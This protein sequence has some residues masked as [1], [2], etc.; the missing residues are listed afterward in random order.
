[1]FPDHV[2]EG[3]ILSNVMTAFDS[4]IPGFS[5][6]AMNLYVDEVIE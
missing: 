5:V 4:A 3:E 6:L 1:M 2:P